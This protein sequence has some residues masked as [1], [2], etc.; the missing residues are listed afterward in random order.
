MTEELE[1]NQVVLEDGTAIQDLPSAN[2]PL[3]RSKWFSGASLAWTIWAISAIFVVFQFFLQLSSGE[4]VKDLMASFHLT[5][6]GGS[7]LASSYYYIYVALQTP[8]GMLMDRFGPRKLLTMGACVCAIGCMLF[9]LAP[10]LTLAIIGRIMMGAGAAFAFVGSL[11]LIAQWFPSSKFSSM[12]GVAEM[13][14]MLGTLAGSLFLAKVLVWFDW[15]VAI[16]GCGV[17]AASLSVAIWM[18]IRDRP[19]PKIVEVN[20]SEEGQ[21][22]WVDLKSLVGNK[23]AWVN[24]L[25]SGL[26]F[27]FVTVFVALWGIPFLMTE[28][29]IPLFA[30][31]LSTNLVF[32]GIAFGSPLM[33]YLDT[34]F[35]LRRHILAASSLMLA[36]LFAAVLF[37]PFINMLAVDIL[38]ILMGCACSAYVITF[39][40]A[41]EIVGPNRRAASLGF[42]NTLSVGTAPLFQPV[43]GWFLH[44]L[45]NKA[46]GVEHYSLGQFQIALSSIVLVLLL[47][48]YL[49][50]L[51]PE[52]PIVD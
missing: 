7:V 29:H 6:F 1:N 34:R 3:L 39:A 41:H 40:V 5:A 31:T 8:A 28:H 13:V 30:A 21:S 44:L 47:G 18:I 42:V 17:F 32:V 9:G 15:R 43:V 23:I 46:S 51:M 26:M 10:D 45:S 12:V 11:Y 49:A 4:I 24:G 22:L 16:A 35:S 38:M 20:D 27:C 2:G 19:V 48:V 52:R 25:Y 33:G 36:L 37:M 50:K 14:G